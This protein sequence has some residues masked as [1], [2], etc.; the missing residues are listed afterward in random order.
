MPYCLSEFTLTLRN[1]S[2]SI[3]VT[4]VAL[5]S[6]LCAGSKAGHARQT[7]AFSGIV[8]PPPAD[9]ETDLWDLPGSLAGHAVEISCVSQGGMRDKN[10]LPDLIGWCQFTPVADQLPVQVEIC[11]CPK[12]FHSLKNALT[13]GGGASGN[14]LVV[15]LDVV[16][17]GA[18]PYRSN[19]AVTRLRVTGMTV[20]VVR[21]FGFAG[22]PQDEGLP[23]LEGAPA[24]SFIN[25]EELMF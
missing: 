24:P 17:D 3:A 9:L 1:T 7:L 2:L 15:T 6:G 4:E 12:I 16:E 21:N 8:S 5:V 25:R 19:S 22:R 13:F 18:T 20:R 14:G 23:V 10:P 11:C